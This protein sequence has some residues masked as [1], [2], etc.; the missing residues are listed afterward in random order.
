MNI[1]DE[2]NKIIYKY[3]LDKYYPHYRKMQE[4]KK[5][6]SKILE[7]IKKEN[8]KV[9][10]V[11]DDGNA[12]KLLRNMAKNVNVSFCNKLTEEAM[13]RCVWDDYDVIYVFS[14]YEV[15]RVFLWMRM[16]GIKHIWLYDIFE[17]S[18]ILFERPFATFGKDS[19]D[20]W[21]PE[22]FLG[23]VRGDNLYLELFFQQRKYESSDNVAV[24]KIALKK[25]LFLTLCLKNFVKAE[26]YF[27]L[28]KGEECFDNAWKEITVLLEKIRVCVQENSKK[29]IILYWMDGIH[30]E[31]KKDMPYLQTR[32]ESGISFEN[33]ITHADNTNPTA[34]A[35]FCKAK[36]VD[37]RSYRISKI[38][39][40]NSPVL[41]C[42][43]KKDYDF[44]VISGYFTI[45]EKQAMIDENLSM[46]ASCSEILWNL[47][48]QLLTAEKNTLY[49]VHLLVEGHAPHLNTRMLEINF[50]Q[51]KPRKQDSCIELDEQLKFYD[52][53]VGGNEYRIYMSD[54]GTADI[55]TNIHVH[56]D[57]VANNLKPRKVSE[58]F[59]LLKFSEVIEQLLMKNTIIP[60]EL[61]TDYAEFQRIDWYN[62]ATIKKIVEERRL[63]G[64]YYFGCKG[65]ITQ[66]YIY[67]RFNTG[68][69]WMVP[70][71]K[72][73]RLEY[74]FGEYICNKELLSSFQRLA[75]IYPKQ[76]SDDD[77]FHDS[78]LL[79]ELYYQRK[80][81]IDKILDVLCAA[82]ENFPENSILIRMGGKYSYQLY[83]VLPEIY[84]RKVSGFVDKDK[85]CLCS[86]FELPIVTPDEINDLDGVRGIIL[87]SYKF[88]TE[89]REEA[90]G[91]SE[92]ITVL[93]IY[94]ECEK[95]GIEGNFDLV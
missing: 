13:E 37:D 16:H 47:M 2:L 54:H 78:K 59:S 12:E 1:T 80:I 89:L 9:I 19:Q 68:K 7:Q 63:F 8:L 94:K 76:V 64:N 38:T 14:F 84:K 83:L 52:S 39:E 36:F 41:R 73:M 77:I 53:F 82:L 58:I 46:W 31:Q 23:K 24:R 87:S 51:L 28:L 3:E 55:F 29:H 45:F 70:R 11:G 18:D 90:R 92:Q 26:E 27:S 6:I 15:E 66:E 32:K 88:I 49:L 61:V 67:L 34:K 4:A 17:E 40:E 65:I 60:K 72:H 71:N 30:Y 22:H 62:E 44:K 50:D 43:A 20:D 10:F 95:K 86:C 81:N 35:M 75:G 74:C 48:Q 5:I 21:F 56:F 33:A 69:Q 25:A 91:Y 42:L 79:Y 85:E 93:D 57:I